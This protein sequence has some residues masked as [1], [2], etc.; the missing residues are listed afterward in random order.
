MRHQARH[1]LTNPRCVQV[2]QFVRNPTPSHLIWEV[3]LSAA[4]PRSPGAVWPVEGGPEISRIE[5]LFYWLDIS[6][7]GRIYDGS[8]DAPVVEVVIQD[9]VVTVKKTGS[10]LRV[11]LDSRL[12]DMG[13]PVTVLAPDFKDTAAKE[14][15]VNLSASLGTVARTMLER[16]DPCLVFEASF[17]LKLSSDGLTW[18][19][20]N[21]SAQQPSAAAAPEEVPSAE[22]I[23]QYKKRLVQREQKYL[24]QVKGM[25]ARGAALKAI[26]IMK[27]DGFKDDAER[28]SFEARDL[29]GEV[30]HLLSQGMCEQDAVLFARQCA[31]LPVDGPVVDSEAAP[32]APAESIEEAPKPT[33]EQIAA[34]K[35]RSVVLEQK[36]LVA[37]GMDPTA[38]AVL[39]IK[40]MK[41]AGE[42]TELEAFRKR[43]LDAEVEHLMSQ[44]LDKQDALSIARQCAGL[45]N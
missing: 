10:W 4:R 22:Q 34:Y 39:A 16:S 31:G 12:V 44:G 24:M 30:A 1:L 42:V 18:E 19:L 20:D 32:E 17:V 36:Y 3:G 13:K 40:R 11:L 7:H 29:E 6:G 35:K 33:H 26:S 21:E 15:Q 38:A 27:G 43:H 45:H 23:S 25:S 37:E 28:T 5:H 41:G 14:F 9:N 2:S 8:Y